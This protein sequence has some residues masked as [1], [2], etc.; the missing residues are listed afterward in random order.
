[1]SEVQA[2]RTCLSAM[3]RVIDEFLREEEHVVDATI[4]KSAKPFS[5]QSLRRD[6]G[7]V[8]PYDYGLAIEP[9]R[10]E[11]DYGF[12]TAIMC[13]IDDV[14][15]FMAGKY[16]PCIAKHHLPSGQSEP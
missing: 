2:L 16:L 8:M 12:N 13:G 3:Q 7:L 10:T 1:M 11:K 15:M 5:P 4:I 14:E 9:E 6:D